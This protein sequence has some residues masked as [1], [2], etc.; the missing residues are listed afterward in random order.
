[1]EKDMTKFKTVLLCLKL[2]TYLIAQKSLSNTEFS[3]DVNFFCFVWKH[4]FWVNL[5]PKIQSF[6]FS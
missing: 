5:A 1:M 6:G 2:L 4:P 3:G